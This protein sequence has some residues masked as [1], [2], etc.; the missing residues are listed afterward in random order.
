MDKKCRLTHFSDAFSLLLF[1]A[2]D[3]LCRLLFW[4]AKVSGCLNA[5]AKTYE[6]KFA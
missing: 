1:T 6:S 5:A 4:K 3:L 2:I